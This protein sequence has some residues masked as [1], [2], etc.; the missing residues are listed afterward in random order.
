MPDTVELRERLAA[1]QREL[2]LVI[3][4]ARS[5]LEKHTHITSDLLNSFE[6]YQHQVGGSRSDYDKWRKRAERVASR[7]REQV[8]RLEA[9]QNELMHERSRIESLLALRGGGYDANDPRSLLRASY[10]LLTRVMLPGYRL[11]E[12]DEALLRALHQHHEG[13]ERDEAQD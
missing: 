4:E 8:E 7:T 11:S 9:R 6:E 12:S 5:L 10:H 1:T 3:G 2:T 13:G